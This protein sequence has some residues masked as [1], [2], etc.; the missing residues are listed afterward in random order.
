MALQSPNRHNTRRKIY[1]NQFFERKKNRDK[2]TFAE[3][4]TC[5]MQWFAP[6]SKLPN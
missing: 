6:T 5:F 1:N 4:C 3:K 2:P